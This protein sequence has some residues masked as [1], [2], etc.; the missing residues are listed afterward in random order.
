MSATKSHKFQGAGVALVTPFQ[1]NLQVDFYGLSRIIDTVVAGG[2]DFI[3]SLGT[4]GEANTLSTEESIR[5]LQFTAERVAKKIPI[6][7]GFF[8]DNSTARLVEKLQHLPVSDFADAIMASSPAYTKPTQE[9]IFQHYMALAAASPLP[10]V[11]YNVPGRT[12][13][14]ILADTTIRLAH[15]SPKFIAVKEASGDIGQ[16]MK[17]LKDKPDHFSLWSGDDILT[18]PL[19][20][21]G[22]T[23]AVSVVANAFPHAFSHMVHEA[24]RYNW[25][26]AQRIHYMLLDLYPL[27]FAEG[28]PSGIKAAME[29][30]GLC[31]NL[32]RLPLTPASESLQAQL[33]QTMNAI[34]PL[35]I[36][37]PIIP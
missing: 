30:L 10:I 29:I 31:K 20:S 18:L 34:T 3:V 25:T 37:H 26:E 32:V 17:I 6:I 16:A 19:I 1:T 12:C 24:L 35:P 9:G 36:P 28:S 7:A 33:T 2:A 21:C 23:G 13:S 22:A 11:I 8:G 5:I 4:T 15:A 27:L 14:N